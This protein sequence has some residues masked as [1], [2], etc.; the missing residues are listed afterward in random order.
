MLKPGASFVANMVT[1]K[2]KTALAHW[3]DGMPI[4]MQQTKAGKVR[5]RETVF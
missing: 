2:S 1:G 3:L 5:K 4:S